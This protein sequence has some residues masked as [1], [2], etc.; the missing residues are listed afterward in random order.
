MNATI[1]RRAL[2]VTSAILA[3]PAAASAQATLETHIGGG[4]SILVAHF[5]RTGNTAVV[6]GIIRRGLGADSF[7]IR[8]RTP[9]PE[10]YEE[11]VDQARRE[12]DAGFEPELEASVPDIARYR[13]IY[14]GLP[15]WG[16]TA[17]PVIRSFLSRHDLAGK[18]L[19][20]FAT[21]GGYGPGDSHTVMAAHAPEARLAEAFV[22][23]ADQER[24]TM[25]RVKGWLAENRT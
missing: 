5:T 25:E 16:A 23:E 1:S 14:L 8:P 20:P 6:A 2:L 3:T 11:T 13:T 21:H 12:R 7:E 22:M 10:D 18:D 15:I 9:Y 17:P 24:R 4:S 19:I